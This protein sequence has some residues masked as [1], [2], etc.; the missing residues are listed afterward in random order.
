MANL[1]RTN[2]S[3]H[4]VPHIFPRDQRL[5]ALQRH[6]DFHIC[7]GA[8][9]IANIVFSGLG[10]MANALGVKAHLVFE[11]FGQAKN[12]GQLKGNIADFLPQ[13]LHA[14]MAQKRGV[15]FRRGL[16]Q[17]KLAFHLGV[18]LA[19]F[20]KPQKP[21]QRNIMHLRHFRERFHTRQAHR[22]RIQNLRQCRSVYAQTMGKI[23]LTLPR[24]G[25][26]IVK[27]FLKRAVQISFIHVFV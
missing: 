19:R 12:I 20:R 9:H 2:G 17:F 11:H 21:I 3:G 27:A 6:N 25:D 8:F 24:G 4:G 5:Q 23:A 7:I 1:A 13:S 18:F 10:H 14:P 16:F 26:D 15:L 22:S